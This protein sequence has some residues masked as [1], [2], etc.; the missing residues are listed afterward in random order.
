MW[1]A[2]MWEPAT[3]RGERQALAAEQ[4]QLARLRRQVDERWRTL[5]LAAERVNPVSPASSSARLDRLYDAYMRAVDAYVA[6]QRALARRA[7]AA[8]QTQRRA[9]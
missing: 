8:A 4:A 1:Q 5:A 3:K 7:D 2:M 6:R 9:S